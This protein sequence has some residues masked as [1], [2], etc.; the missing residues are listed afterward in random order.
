[1]RPQDYAR[2]WPKHLPTS[3][4]VPQTSVWY[5]LEVSARRYPG[6]AAVIFYGSRLSYADLARDAGRLAGFLRQRC[7]IARGDRVLLSAQ[8]SPQFIVAYYATLR[9]NAVIVPVGPMNVTA[10]IAHYVRDSGAR[11]AI[12]AQELFQQ[13]QPLLRKVSD[14]SDTCDNCLTHVIVGAVR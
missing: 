2:V 13:Y 6:K 14:V 12:V 1:M 5:N 4:T 7:G 3:L 11:T 9:C 8:N 10:E